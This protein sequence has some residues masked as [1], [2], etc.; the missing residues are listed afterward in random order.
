MIPRIEMNN[1]SKNKTERI[2]LVYPGTITSSDR[3]RM[4]DYNSEK[5]DHVDP[6]CRP[7]FGINVGN[8]SLSEVNWKCAYFT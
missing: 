2:R 3:N 6:G 1:H 5:G 7:S 8:W 4:T